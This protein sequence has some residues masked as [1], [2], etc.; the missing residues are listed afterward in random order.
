M[1]GYA[2]PLYA[3]S[4]AEFGTPRQLPGSGGWILQRRIGC[5]DD[6]DGMGCYPLFTC[7]DWSRL[8][9]DLEELAQE[10]VSLT[11][12]SDPFAD[13][14]PG[15]LQRTFELARPFKQHFVADLSLPVENIVSSHHARCTRRARQ[16]ITVE[17]TEQPYRYLNEWTGLYANLSE[18]FD[19]KG[20]RAFSP[21]A[22]R[23]QLAIPGAVMFR[24]LHQGVAVTSHL[25]LRRGDV[26]YGHLVGSSPLGQKLMASY[27]LYWTEL[28]YFA[29]RARWFDWGGAA[30]LNADSDCGLNK[31]KRGWSTGTRN[32]WLCG[33]IFRHQRYAELVRE[34]AQPESGDYFPAYRA[35]EFG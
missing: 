24:A 27:P 3:H 32:S 23:Q 1:N 2:D 25:V 15:L 16:D 33:R 13:C 9:E 11:L 29:G 6:W 17:I 12:V 28:E 20:I 14:E 19:V 34:H 22:F 35:G 18:R 5:G 30:G 4:L 26:C 10:L 31:F 21:E 7:R 8:P